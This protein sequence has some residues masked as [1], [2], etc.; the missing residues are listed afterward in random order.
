MSEPVFLPLMTHDQPDTAERVRRAV[1][2]IPFALPERIAKR[3]AAMDAETSLAVALILER[4]EAE[5][6]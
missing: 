5:C 3:M 1:Q 4:E 2:A 6:P